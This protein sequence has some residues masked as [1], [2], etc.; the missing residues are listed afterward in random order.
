MKKIIIYFCL[1]FLSLNIANSNEK[2]EDEILDVLTNKTFEPSH[3]I[4]SAFSDA[5]HK[6]KVGEL[7][8][9]W[10]ELI[11]KHSEW[12]DEKIRVEGQKA[13]VRRN[14]AWTFQDNMLRDIINIIVLL[15]T[16]VTITALK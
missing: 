2:S 15:G 7:P 16:M 11:G 5:I 14:L 13:S 4:R 10:R 3:E 6:S 12:L 1:I 9:F 8:Q